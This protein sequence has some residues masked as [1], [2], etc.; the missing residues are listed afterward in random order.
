MQW[1]KMPRPPIKRPNPHWLDN[2][3]VTTDLIYRYQVNERTLTDVLKADIYALK[4][5]KQV[6]YFKAPLSVESD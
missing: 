3:N 5:T 6:S 4:H 2:I 1:D